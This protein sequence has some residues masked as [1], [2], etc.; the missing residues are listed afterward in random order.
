MAFNVNNPLCQASHS[1]LPRKASVSDAVKADATNQNTPIVPTASDAVSFTEK[2]MATPETKSGKEGQPATPQAPAI[3]V[4]LAGNPRRFSLAPLVTACGGILGTVLG[5]VGGYYVANFVEDGTSTTASNKTGTTTY[6]NQSAK[7]L[8]EIEQ[9][10]V[11]LKKGGEALVL[12]PNKLTA[13]SNTDNHYYE[14]TP[15]AIQTTEAEATFEIIHHHPTQN[16]QV[17]YRYENPALVADSTDPIEPVLKQ[18][19]VLTPDGLNDCFTLNAKGQPINRVKTIKTSSGNFENHEWQFAYDNHNANR[20]VERHVIYPA[21]PNASG[22]GFHTADNAVATSE[23]VYEKIYNTAAGFLQEIQVLEKGGKAERLLFDAEGNA[24]ERF[25]PIAL[26]QAERVEKVLTAK[27]GGA[28]DW[29]TTKV[30]DYKQS[31]QPNSLAEKW[32]K[33]FQASGLDV[34]IND[35]TSV[36]RVAA[37]WFQDGIGTNKLTSK[38]EIQYATLA[39]AGLVGVVH[40]QTQL[41]TAIQ[42]P[43]FSGGEPLLKMTAIAWQQFKV[44]YKESGGAIVEQTVGDRFSSLTQAFKETSVGQKIG[45]GVGAVLGGTLGIWALLPKKHKKSDNILKN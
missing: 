30:N 15:K 2:A 35:L 3:K 18:I 16:I 37:Q 34:L 29:I 33:F 45:L 26:I 24:T 6:I 4:P 19:N 38:T 12:N 1:C 40:P 21:T 13:T 41:R 22:K 9:N 42:Q 36:E 14:F 10:P 44:A 25:E 32:E 7:T 28:E 23:T 31:I 27:A 5:G 8:E 20:T 39:K 11:Y 17:Q 43:A